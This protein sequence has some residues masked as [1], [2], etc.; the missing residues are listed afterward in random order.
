MRSTYPSKGGFQFILTGGLTLSLSDMAKRRIFPLVVPPRSCLLYPG[1]PASWSQLLL[2]VCSSPSLCLNHRRL[3]SWPRSLHRSYDIYYLC[4]QNNTRVCKAAL[5]EK[6][7]FLF[8]IPHRHRSSMCRDPLQPLKHPSCVWNWATLSGTL[9]TTTCY[10][11]HLLQQPSAHSY[12]LTAS[13]L[14]CAGVSCFLGLA[15]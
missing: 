14:S 4:G 2:L 13:C 12:S 10:S 1:V 8:E 6:D 5:T 11:G 9:L 7:F 15:Q 3:L